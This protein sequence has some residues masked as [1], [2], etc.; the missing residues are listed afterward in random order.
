MARGSEAAPQEG[1]RGTG[2]VKGTEWRS[3]SGGLMLWEEGMFLAMVR[4]P[5]AVQHRDRVTGEQ[6]REQN[7]RA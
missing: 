1:L 3:G 6:G 4:A 2:K 5:C 7:G